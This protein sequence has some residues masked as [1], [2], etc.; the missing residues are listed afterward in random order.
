MLC[1]DTSKYQKRTHLDPLQLLPHRL[2]G[3]AC[4]PMFFESSVR[5]ATE[6]FP[7]QVHTSST[8][9]VRISYQCLCWW[10]DV[11]TL[12]SKRNLRGKQRPLIL[13]DEKLN[14]IHSQLQSKAGRR[15]SICFNFRAIISLFP[16]PGHSQ[17][18]RQWWQVTCWRMASELW[19]CEGLIKSNEYFVVP[20]F[21]MATLTLKLI[22]KRLW[23][24]EI[25][26]CDV[27]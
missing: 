13:F 10:I 11:S 25:K 16:A 2:A 27:N 26:P 15:N 19:R 6:A 14:G 7:Q 17:W 3:A 21:F 23:P 5:L 1:W 4:S 18:S 20:G 12:Q 24:N 9:S 8:S 22:S